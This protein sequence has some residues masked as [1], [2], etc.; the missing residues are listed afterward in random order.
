M[1]QFKQKQCLKQQIISQTTTDLDENGMEIE[2]QN[3][4][5]FETRK[6]RAQSEPEEETTSKRTRFRKSKSLVDNL[7]TEANYLRFR[8]TFEK[9]DIVQLQEDY[10]E[11]EMDTALRSFKI[12][13]DLHLH[14][15]GFK[16]SAPKAP[17]FSV[18]ILPND[19]P[20]PSHNEMI[21]CQRQELT[22]TVPLLVIS[23]SE[24][25]QIQAF[26]YYT[27]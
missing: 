9:F 3:E 7:K 27:S 8:E 25:K 16:R 20:F 24:S 2:T 4:F 15:E 5:K 17:T 14:N 22:H 18:I 12:T 19:E 13:F 26:L 10:Y 6:R 11:S 1:Y 21:K 23:V